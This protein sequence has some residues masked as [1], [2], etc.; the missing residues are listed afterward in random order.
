MRSIFARSSSCRAQARWIFAC[1]SIATSREKGDTSDFGQLD[2]LGKVA[3][4]GEIVDRRRHPRA[5]LLRRQPGVVIGLVVAGQL[6]QRPLVQG[7]GFAR[8]VGPDQVAVKYRRGQRF[9]LAK[10]DAANA[11]ELR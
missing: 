1:R 2:R 8:A 4:R 10:I 11:V 6:R 5:K 3:S 9:G 7:D